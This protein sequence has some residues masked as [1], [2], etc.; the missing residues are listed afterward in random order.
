M[1]KSTKPAVNLAAKMFL[2]P[3][4]VSQLFGGCAATWRKLANEGALPSY[5]IGRVLLVFRPDEVQAYLEANRNTGPCPLRDG[6][7]RGR[8]PGPRPKG[9]RNSRSSRSSR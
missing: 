2:G 5:R 6:R 1:T 8:R 9:K 4:E 7:R 3:A